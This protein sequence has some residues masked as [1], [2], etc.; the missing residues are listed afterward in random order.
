MSVVSGVF[1]SLDDDGGTRSTNRVT[2]EADKP[3]F[4]ED[5]VLEELERLRGAIRL[6]RSKREEKVAQFESFVRDARMAARREAARAVG[7]DPD[8]DLEV[9][10][11]PAL[12]VGSSELTPI[13]SETAA[14]WPPPPAEPVEQPV[15]AARVSR[16]DDMSEATAAFPDPLPH[17]RA[18]DTYI[19]GASAGVLIIALLVVS[20]IGGDSEPPATPTAAQTQ[21]TPGGQPAP[22]AAIPPKTNQAPR[23]AAGPAASPAAPTT[24]LPLQVELVA[25]RKVWMRV[26]VDGDRAIEDEV[27]EGQR[28]RFAANRSIVVRA[29]DAGAVTISVDGQAA[30]PLGRAGQPATRTL[31]PRAK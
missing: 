23:S 20:T 17:R 27:E 22:G 3:T 1:T 15:P 18:L 7:V 29:G 4:D 11:A 31:S 5:S 24:P 19:I 25:L 14:P 2:N 26:T 9:K 6:A 12:P 16:L 21:T 8:D 30:A 13:V 28:L 10:T